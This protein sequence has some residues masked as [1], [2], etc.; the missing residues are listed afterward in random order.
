MPDHG[1]PVEVSLVI[2]ARP[3][4]IFRYFTD[5]ARFAR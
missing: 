2:A 4:T 5:P 3:G 1:D